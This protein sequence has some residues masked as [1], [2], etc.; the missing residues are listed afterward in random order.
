MARERSAGRFGRDGGGDSAAC[1]EGDGS[2][3]GCG[4]GGGCPGGN[5]GEGLS[6]GERG[7][8]LLACGYF[9]LARSRGVGDVWLRWDGAGMVYTNLGVVRFSR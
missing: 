2:G 8:E 7:L 1:G 3:S 4:H 6:E 5:G 9:V